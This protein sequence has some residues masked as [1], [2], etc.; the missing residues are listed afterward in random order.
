MKLTNNPDN[1]IDKGCIISLLCIL[2]VFFIACSKPK[3]VMIK[4]GNKEISKEELLAYFQR[5][6]SDTSV[7]KAGAVSQL[8]EELILEEEAKKL[9]VSLSKEELEN[10][11]KEN[12]I[13]EQNISTAKLYLLRQKVAAT[14]AKDIEPTKERIETIAA[15]M[16]DVVAERYIFQQIL[17]NKEE[18]AFKVL[19]E[20]KKGLPFEDAAKK[21]SI[22]P[23]GKK[24][25]LIDYLDAE[26]LPS[27]LLV[28]LK[29]LKP[30]EISGVVRSAFGFH[31]L[32]LKDVVK[33]RKLSKEEKEA[34]AKEEA[35]KQ[36]AGENYADWF[37]KKRKE[38]NVTVKWEEIE[39]LK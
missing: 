39:K 8:I 13:K 31:I 34:A 25:G 6:S 33:S 27:E 26:E 17:L 4:V 2:F 14:L 15:E 16:K 10:F 38:Y 23:E 18:N 7:K 5:T 11:V 28:V 37:A 24:G 35:K 36:L 9:N 29:K 1:F 22:S 21:Y 30:N 20:I 12:N 32:K 19:E 3:E